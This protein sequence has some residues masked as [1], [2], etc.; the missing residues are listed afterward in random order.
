MNSV[1]HEEK[2]RDEI[3]NLNIGGTHKIATSI[4]ILTACEDSK[5]TKIMSDRDGLMM[6]GNEIFLDRDGP[7]FI[8]MLNYLRN[9]RK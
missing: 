4:R 6:T 9:D 3:V 5:L 1:F 7:T 8:N 2:N